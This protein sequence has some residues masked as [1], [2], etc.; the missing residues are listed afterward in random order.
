MLKAALEK[1]KKSQ[2]KKNCKIVL[3]M[4]KS[5]ILKKTEKEHQLKQQ[6]FLEQLARNIGNSRLSYTN[7]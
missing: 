4:A 5:E 3:D 1:L 2:F 7:I 6:Q